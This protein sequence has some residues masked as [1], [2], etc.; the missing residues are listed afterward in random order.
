MSKSKLPQ[1]NEQGAREK[2]KPAGWSREKA[3]ALRAAAKRRNPSA[4]NCD[5]ACGK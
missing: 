4:C 3:E 1:P 2:R 5:C